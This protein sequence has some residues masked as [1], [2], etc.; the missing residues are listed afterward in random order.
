MGT[1]PKKLFCGFRLFL[2][3]VTPISLVDIPSLLICRHLFILLLYRSWE[4]Q[5]L[6]YDMAIKPL[7]S[8][9]NIRISGDKKI[10]LYRIYSTT[11]S[12]YSVSYDSIKLMVFFFINIVAQMR[13]VAYGPLVHNNANNTNCII[14]FCLQKDIGY[15][16]CSG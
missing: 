16:F 11:L 4:L 10:S 5:C 3:P 9:F 6:I 12:R 8:M 14:K 7:W 15:R 13:N 2:W 1:E